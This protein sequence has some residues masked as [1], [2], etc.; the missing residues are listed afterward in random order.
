M[1][2]TAKRYDVDG[3][4]KEVG[5]ELLLLAAVIMAAR[6][7]FPPHDQM[8]N[9]KQT[10]HGANIRAP[11]QSSI[12]CFQPIRLHS[13]FMVQGVGS[14]FSFSSQPDSTIIIYK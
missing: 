3:H 1:P 10:R 5:L 12:V 7:V 11:P 14:A 9:A 6:T 2:G 13:L 8:S 4:G